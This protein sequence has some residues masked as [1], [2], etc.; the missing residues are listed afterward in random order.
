MGEAGHADADGL[1]EF[2][3]IEGGRVAFDRGI[4]G[5]D[6]FVDLSVG[7]TVEKLLDA[8]RF[9]TDAVHRGEQAVK[10]VVT[11]LVFVDPFHGRNVFRLGDDAEERAVAARVAANFAVFVL[12]NV[13]A[14]GAETEF[15][16]GGDD[17]GGELIAIVLG[18]AQQMISQALSRF[19]SDARELFKLGD[20]LSEGAGKGHREG[21]KRPIFLRLRRPMSEVSNLQ[22][23]DFGHVGKDALDLAFAELGGGR[24][25]SAHG[26]HD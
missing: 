25:A 16:F 3:E 1:K 5:E 4:G 24:E 7:E 14:V 21:A 8:E 2:G 23:R 12:A 22:T 6:N 18:G 19:R 15:A 26:G 9:G 10:H 13:L 11:A 17:R 20:Q